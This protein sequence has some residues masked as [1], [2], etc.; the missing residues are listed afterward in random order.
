MSSE[1]S[2]ETEVESGEGTEIDL[3]KLSKNGISG[4]PDADNQSVLNEAS[5]VHGSK[6]TCRDKKKDPKT[7]QV[8]DDKNDKSKEM[9]S[10]ETGDKA[11]V[12]TERKSLSERKL[13]IQS[14]LQVNKNKRK[15]AKK[16]PSD[17]AKKIKQKGLTVNNLTT[18]HLE[19]ITPSTSVSKHVFHFLA[20]EGIH[21]NRISQ[22]LSEGQTE[23]KPLWLDNVGLRW[24]DFERPPRTVVQDINVRISIPLKSLNAEFHCP[25]CLGYVKRA[26]IV[27]VCLHRFCAECIEKCL[28]LGKRECPSCRVHIPSRRSLRPD[29]NF[30]SLIQTIF[31]NL[32]ELEL[33]Q[34]KEIELLNKSRNMN[35]AYSESRR[36]AILQQATQRVSCLVSFI[37]FTLSLPCWYT[38]YYRSNVL[39]FFVTAEKE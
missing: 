32:Q 37:Y 16:K 36:R 30:D 18:S 24:Y 9:M 19:S 3:G 12:P 31:G 14:E 15:P 7:Q 28:R 25:V 17:G 10:S 33:R 29:P 34:E 2:T 4:I 5:I 21:F 13:E 38:I 22:V 23:E 6:D 11:I 8:L 39:C 1:A 26:S 35:N 20:Q 27:M